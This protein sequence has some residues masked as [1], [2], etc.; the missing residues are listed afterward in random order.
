MEHQLEESILEKAKM[1]EE[2]VE[3][4]SRLKESTKEGE[5]QKRK[6]IDLSHENKKLELRIF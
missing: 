4:S 6:L 2:K 1:L 3:L 5:D